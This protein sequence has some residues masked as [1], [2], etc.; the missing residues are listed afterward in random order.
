VTTDD[1]DDAANRAPRP[2]I[3][4]GL[5][6]LA[7]T[8]ALAATWL[9]VLR[10]ANNDAISVDDLVNSDVTKADAVTT[11]E[12]GKPAPATSLTGFD[13]GTVTLASLVG[14]PV[15]INFWASSCVP[16]IKE[17]PL[18]ERAHQQYGDAVAFLGVD[19]F[20]APDLGREMIA[21][22]GVTYPQTVDP[23]NDVLTSF[24]GVALPHTVILRADGTV[25]ALHNE[26]I[27]DDQVLK[28]LVT[29]AEK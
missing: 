22:T 17:M 18:L 28:D 5:T 7:M 8:A 13:G 27:T 14:K 4:I 29:A 2:H 6:L 1:A 25:S 26:A 12:V 16:C 10:P 11:A 21:K 23:T 3:F 20:E 9:F 19:V 15:V 24:G